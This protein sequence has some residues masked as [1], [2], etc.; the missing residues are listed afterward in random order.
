[1]DGLCNDEARRD[2]VVGLEA[3][4]GRQ[5]AELAVVVWA[6]AVAVPAAR[7]EAVKR[8]AQQEVGVERFELRAD[9]GGKVAAGVDDPADFVRVRGW[10]E[11]A[12]ADDA[13]V[14]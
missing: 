10:G 2:E 1:M 12:G 11:E 8:L 9:G 6:G 14:C 13:W 4:L 3:L 5:V 7:G